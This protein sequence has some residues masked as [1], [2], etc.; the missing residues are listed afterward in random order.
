MNLK[1]NNNNNIKTNQKLILFFFYRLH[2]PLLPSLSN[3]LINIKQLPSKLS[4]L[5]A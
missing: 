2:F 5:S 1:F 3:L 4:D